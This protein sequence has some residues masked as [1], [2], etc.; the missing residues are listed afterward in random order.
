MSGSE[1]ADAVWTEICALRKL[2]SEERA[3]ARSA[4]HAT[5]EDGVLATERSER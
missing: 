5:R 3:Q 4:E 2:R 1:G